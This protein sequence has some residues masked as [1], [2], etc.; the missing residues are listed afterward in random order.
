M[1]LMAS[2]TPMSQQDEDVADDEESWKYFLLSFHFSDEETWHLGPS[3]PS[4]AGAR[5]RDSS[6]SARR[7]RRSGDPELGDPSHGRWGPRSQDLPGAGPPHPRDPYRGVWESVSSAP[8]ACAGS[9]ACQGATPDAPGTA[10]W[11][12]A[13]ATLG[14]PPGAGGGGRRE[15]SRGGGPPAPSPG[16]R[17]SGLAP[18]PPPPAPPLPGLRARHSPGPP[19]GDTAGPPGSRVRAGRHQPSWRSSRGYFVH[20]RAVSLRRLR[21]PL[22]PR[23]APLVA[24]GA[25]PSSRAA[26]P[27]SSPPRRPAQPS[28]AHLPPFPI[29]PLPP[30]TKSPHPRPRPARIRSRAH[31]ASPP[32]LPHPF[33]PPYPAIAYCPFLLGRP[34][35]TN[36]ENSASFE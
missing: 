5:R 12:T 14:S 4:R 15:Q 24:R 19:I 22:A 29:L 8:P 34:Q 23:A 20:A 30:T 13:A 2:Q 32:T 27:A 26:G 7:P 11:A 3:E 31:R 21:L 18:T 28:P 36:G 35:L 17:W 10:G 6:S 25:A 33:P 1:E 16:P 9:R